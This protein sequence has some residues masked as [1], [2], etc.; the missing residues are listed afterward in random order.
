MGFVRGGL[1]VVVSVL[2]FVSFLVGGALLTMSKSLEYDVL[3]PEFSAVANDLVGIDLN[4]NELDNFAEEIY[5]AEYN[6]DFWDC[7]GDGQPLFLVS[8]KARNYWNSKFYIVIGISFVLLVL[9]FFL[10]ESKINFPF[11][12]GILLVVASLPFVKLESFLLY[13]SENS[14]FQYLAIFFSK[15]F[16]VFFRMIV[17]GIVIF[18]I[19]ILF[20]FFDFGFKIHGFFQR[21]RQKGMV[22]GGVKSNSQGISGSKGEEKSQVFVNKGGTKNKLVVRKKEV[23]DKIVVGK[24][25]PIG[26]I[27][28]QKKAKKSSKNAPAS[29]GK[30]FK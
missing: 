30:N 21:F 20:K 7:F 25:E 19:G 26:K 27:T 13:F 22:E 17:F 8:E 12:V 6:C 28:L 2:L 10:V 1:F 14:V 11:V 24:K 23:K 29:V 5:Y 15:S 3:E 16:Y 18:A 9:M 4:S